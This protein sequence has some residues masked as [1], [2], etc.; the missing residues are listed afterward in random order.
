MRR[1]LEALPD[2]VFAARPV[3][4]VHV[5]G[6]LP[7]RA[8]TSRAWRRDSRRPNGGWTGDGQDDRAP[9]PIV[10]DEEEF[11]RLPAFDRRV[12]RG[13]GA[14]PRRRRRDDHPCPARAGS[15]RGGRPPRPRV[16]GRGFLGLAYW[17]SGDLEAAHRFVD[18]RDRQPASGRGTSRTSSAASIALADIRIGARSTRRRDAARTSG[19]WTSSPGPGEPVLR[20]AADMHVGDERGA[21]RAERSRRERPSTCGR[22]RSS[23]SR[24]ASRRT[25]IAGVSRWLASARL[26]ATSTRPS[27]LLDE[28]ERRYTSDYFPNVRPIPAMKARVWIAQGRLDRAAA[29][30]REHGVSVEDDLS[31]LREFDHITLARLLM[32]GR[33]ATA[34]RPLAAG[35]S[36]PPGAPPGR[37]RRQG[38]GTRSV[39]ELLVLQALDRQRQAT[40]GPPLCRW[41][42]PSTLAEPEG[43]VRIFVDEGRPMVGP[44]RVRPR[45]TASP[46]ATSVDCWRPWARA[47][48]LRPATRRWSS[49]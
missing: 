24:W 3:L 12:P 5:V 46:R 1:W 30:A 6:A 31:Y 41:D 43:Y 2:D 33:A 17:T 37:R 34:A 18:R 36:G 20:G 44:A 25:R 23:A 26:K 42:A 28:A 38:S 15:R 4:S 49:H 10:V 35:G 22:A 21:P 40:S 14:W 16:R 11:R 29:W 9:G 7:R 27:T 32:P 45:D 8:A 39:I 48:T 13:A 47:G 19:D